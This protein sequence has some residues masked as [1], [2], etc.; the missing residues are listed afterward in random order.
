MRKANGFTLIELLAVIIIM[1]II[2]LITIP[3]I[4][5]IIENARKEAFKDSAYGIVSAAETKYMNSLLG[6]TSEGLIYEYANGKIVSGEDLDYRGETPK[7]GRVS[8][9]KEGKIGIAIDNGKWCATK[10]YDENEVSLKKLENNNCILEASES[11]NIYDE[12]TG[13]NKPQLLTNMIPIKWDENNNEIVTDKNDDEWYA[14]EEK[15]WANA[16]TED[17]SYWV[18]IPRYAYKITSGYH[19][20]TA[21]TIDIKFLKGN[22]NESVD[23]TAI[24]TS[25]YK[26]GVKDTSTNYFLHPSFDNGNELGYWVAKFEPSVKENDPCYTDESET[27]CNK[28]N[29]AIEILPNKTSLSYISASNAYHVS[30]NMKDY[31]G[32]GTID[33]HMMTNLQWGAVAYL[34]KSVYGAD[35]QEVWNNVDYYEHKTGCSG[36]GVDAVIEY[37]CVEYNTP[38]GV[39]ASTTH[40]ITGIY[41]MSG[42]SYEFVMGNY[43]NLPANSGFNE[44]ELSD[45]SAQYL[46]KYKTPAGQMLNGF[47]MDY[48]MGIYGDAMYETSNNAARDNGSSATGNGAGSWYGDTSYLPY[49]YASWVLRGGYYGYGTSAGVFSFENSTGSFASFRPVL[50]AY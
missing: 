6:K 4:L 10:D 5:N 41:D 24:E 23:G 35:N 28:S 45:L 17:G 42:G 9:T 13:I 15:R 32:G 1:A 2:A 14:Y 39:K 50:S 20:S 31:I 36:S 43:N 48:D 12:V 27:N 25:G 49:I 46:T 47:G 19:T 11:S 3:T 34:S 29:L 22:T 26:V 30:K 44:T 33:S 38:N 21:G 18:W 8:I 16:K 7:S 40:N 37:P